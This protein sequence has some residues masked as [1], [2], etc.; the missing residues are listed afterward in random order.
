MKFV[1]QK[2]VLRVGFNIFRSKNLILDEKNCF[3][4]LVFGATFLGKQLWFI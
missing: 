3:K 1:L 4:M 2:Y